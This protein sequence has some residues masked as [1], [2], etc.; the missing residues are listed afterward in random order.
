LHKREGVMKY[1][2]KE[3]DRVYHRTLGYGTVVDVRQQPIPETA[4]TPASMETRVVTRLE[5]SP[6]NSTL[7][8]EIETCVHHDAM[9]SMLIPEREIF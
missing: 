1:R 8:L 4:Y 9:G 5:Q 3:G 7:P 6:H 2:Y